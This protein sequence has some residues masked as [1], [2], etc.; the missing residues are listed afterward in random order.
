MSLEPPTTKQP[1][2]LSTR[3]SRLSLEQNV[4]TIPD[5]GPWNHAMTD[6]CPSRPGVHRFKVRQSSLTRTLSGARSRA[7]AS[8]RRRPKKACGSRPPCP[9]PHAPPG[10]KRRLLRRHESIG[11]G[12]LGLEPIPLTHR[13]QAVRIS[14]GLA[15]GL[16]RLR[17]L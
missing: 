9:E 13:T 1:P 4:G 2:I 11:P 3:Q 15:R 12:G 8:G 14:L 7:V 10:P 5:L 6:A 16:G 17:R